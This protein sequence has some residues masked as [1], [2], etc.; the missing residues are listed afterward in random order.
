VELLGKSIFYDVHLSINQNQSCVSCH[1][2]GT[3]WT[4]PDSEVNLHGAVYEGSIPDRFGNRK[5]PSAAYATESPIF[6]FVNGGDPT[7]WGGNFWD[8]RAT[9]ELLGNPAADLT[10][11]IFLDTLMQALPDSACAV[12]R[13]CNPVNPN[14]YPVSFE[15]VWGAGACDITWPADIET[16]CATE[17]ATVPLTPAD[18]NKSDIAYDEIGLTVARYLASAEVN[19][20]TSKYDQYLAGSTQLSGQE[21]SGLTLFKTK[22]RCINCH[23]VDPG[24][25]GELPLLTNFSY[26]NIG[27]PKNPENPFYGMP[28]PFNPDG[29]LWVDKGLGEFLESRSEF[30]AYVAANIGKHK[31]PTLRNLDERQSA[32]F[33]KAYTHNGYFKSLKEIVHFFNT[34]DVLPTCTGGPGEIEGITC[35]P[36]PEVSAN[37]NTTDMGNL[38]LS[39]AE[40]DAIVVFLKTLSDDYS[41]TEGADVPTMNQWGFTIFAI[42]LAGSVVW[43]IRRKQR[44]S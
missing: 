22:G 37:I 8:G 36:A 30:S 29:N 31:T 4:G 16:L 14:D 26:V 44:I 28:P 41:R 32:G 40:E 39:E 13:V 3:G 1:A 17:G 24:P 25:G 43:F 38:L 34:R 23:S 9:G 18:R 42:L 33:V 10:T 15:T 21:N 27:V 19:Q 35:W 7:F 20:F 12:Y 5:P 6:H 11:N 2:P